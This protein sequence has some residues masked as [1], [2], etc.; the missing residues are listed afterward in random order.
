[1]LLLHCPFCGPRNEIEFAHGGPEKKRRPD[2]TSDIEDEMWIEYLT[3]SRNPIGPVA[4]RWWHVRGCGGWFTIY[5]DT[6]THDI[7]DE[8]PL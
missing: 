4:E 1:M 7:I 5:R 8:G 6:R 3:V 2:S